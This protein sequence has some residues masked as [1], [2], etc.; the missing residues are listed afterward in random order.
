VEGAGRLA[1]AF[2]MN[3]GAV[4]D[5]APELIVGFA[6]TGEADRDGVG[7]GIFER[8]QLTD[9][10]DVEAVDIFAKPLEQWRIRICFHGIM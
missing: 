9:R 5:R 6:W 10:G 8:F 4:L 7:A 3:G 2:K 1:L